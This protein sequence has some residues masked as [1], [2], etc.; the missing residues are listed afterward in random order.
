MFDLISVAKH[1]LLYVNVKLNIY[2]MDTIYFIKL[3]YALVS[4]M[5]N[6]LNQTYG[7]H[8]EF[9]ALLGYQ[10]G[11]ALRAVQV[12]GYSHHPDQF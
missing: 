5:L 1:R 7:S 10:Q 12:P 4:Y 3:R 8:D 11:R 2:I 6:R 9:D